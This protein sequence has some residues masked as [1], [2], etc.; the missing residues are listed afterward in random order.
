M[1]QKVGCNKK[2]MRERFLDTFTFRNLE[3]IGRLVKTTFSM[4]HIEGLKEAGCA[5]H[6]LRE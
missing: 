5:S 1:G 6:G 3:T 2:G 4:F